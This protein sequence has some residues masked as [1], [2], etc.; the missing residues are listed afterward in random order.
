MEQPQIPGTVS[1][2]QS[3]PINKPVIVKVES[4]GKS[5]LKVT[6]DE[7]MIFDGVVT[8][9]TQKIWE[10]KENITIE[11]SNAGLILVA[12]NNQKAQRLGKLGES[13]KVSYYL[14]NIPN[15]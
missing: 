11:A 15:K 4:T 7:K 13:T 9:D 10:A 3:Q 1:S 2:P 6:V 5:T 14:T 12:F 8:K